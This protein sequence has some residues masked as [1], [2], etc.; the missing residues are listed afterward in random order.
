[1]SLQCIHIIIPLSLLSNEKKLSLPP[2]ENPILL[3]VAPHSFSSMSLITANLFNLSLNLFV[4]ASHINGIIGIT[5]CVSFLHWLLLSDVMFSSFIFVDSVHHFIAD[6]CHIVWLYHNLFDRC[7]IVW[8]Y[9]NLFAH[10]VI[11]E[12]LASFFFYLW[13]TLSNAVE[14]IHVLGLVWP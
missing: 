5:P 8:L 10:I 12:H 11:N 9:Q 2:K 4:L 13:I 1:M 6:Q 7:S 3:V 14:S